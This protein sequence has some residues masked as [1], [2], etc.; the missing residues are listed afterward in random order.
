MTYLAD[1]VLRSLK[2][3][4]TATMVLGGINCRRQGFLTHVS[5]EDVKSCLDSLVLCGKIQLHQGHY[6]R[7]DVRNLT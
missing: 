7:Y 3:P 4:S 1:Q 5:Y 2:K 6:S